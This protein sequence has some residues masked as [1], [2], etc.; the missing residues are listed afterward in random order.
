MN[1]TRRKQR[2]PRLGAEADFISVSACVVSERLAPGGACMFCLCAEPC[3][4][5]LD[6]CFAP[7]ITF[8]PQVLWPRGSLCFLRFF[9]FLKR[10]TGSLEIRVTVVDCQPSKK[11]KGSVALFAYSRI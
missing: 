6:G 2:I 10:R 8:G 1:W 11:P 5:D 3:R 9:F 7:I 4:K